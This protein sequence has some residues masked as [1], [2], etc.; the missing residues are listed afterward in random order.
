VTMHFLLPSSADRTYFAALALGAAF[1]ST[2]ATIPPTTPAK[3]FG[4]F[5]QPGK[6]A[7]AERRDIQAE[8][9]AVWRRASVNSARD[10][11]PHSN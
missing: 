5:A 10:E 8:Q 6:K 7:F 1:R 11:M 4:Y 3:S 9:A 2:S